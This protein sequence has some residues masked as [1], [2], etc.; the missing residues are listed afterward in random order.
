MCLGESIQGFP[1]MRGASLGVTIIWTSISG[2][3][4]GS[5]I[6]GKKHI[7]ATSAPVCISCPKWC[8]IH[9]KATIRRDS[10]Q[11]NI[12]TAQ[13]SP[14]LL[15]GMQCIASILKEILL[16]NPKNILGR[17]S[18]YTNIP[19]RIL[20]MSYVPNLFLSHSWVAVP[21]IHIS[22]AGV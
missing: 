13:K 9:S 22:G 8:T 4:F 20:N 3:I 18:E 10:I 7:L 2:S 12:Q 17:Y 11:W 15:Q 5:P 6:Y 1:K 14:A 16:V 21:F 19:T